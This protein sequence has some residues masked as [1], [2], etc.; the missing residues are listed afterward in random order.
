[1]K[2]AKARRRGR[3]ADHGGMFTHVVV[4]PALGVL[5]TIPAVAEMRERI[6][7]ATS[8]EHGLRDR[9]HHIDQITCACLRARGYA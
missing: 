7:A 9:S 6:E 3:A 1:M 5:L 2:E 8:Q 4:P